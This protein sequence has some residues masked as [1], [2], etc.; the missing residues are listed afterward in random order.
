MASYDR[1]K[2]VN[3]RNR[4]GISQLQTELCRISKEEKNEMR[5]HNNEK[6][7]FKKKYSKLD[8]FNDNAVTEVFFFRFNNF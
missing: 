5:M 7:R 4:V 1:M 8:L 3:K 2:L 6:Q